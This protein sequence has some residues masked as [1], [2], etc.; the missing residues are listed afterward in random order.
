MST[1]LSIFP[2]L[3][4]LIAAVSCKEHKTTVSESAPVSEREKEKSRDIHLPSTDDHYRQV[5]SF[6]EE[7]PDADYKHAPEDAYESFNDMKFGIRIH[8]GI[9]SIWQMDHES[10]G[11]LKLTNEK[12]Q[13]YQNLYK[14]FNPTGFNAEEWMSFF[15]SAGLKVFAFT[16]KHHEGFS[17]FDTKAHVKQRANYTAPGGPKIEDCDLAYSI[18]ETPFKRDIVKELCDAAHKHK[19]KIDLYFSHPDWYDADFRPYNFHPLQTEDS[20][21]NPLRN[22]CD[23]NN[24]KESFSNIITP[25]PT[26]EATERMMARHRQQLTELLTN[27]GKIDMLC[28][29]QWFG[30][31]VWPQTKATIK[32][33]RKIQPDVM[34]RC[35]GIGNYGDYY[36]PEGFTPG[37]KEN[38]HMPWMVI[39]TLG[40]TF[41][42]DK[43][44]AHYKGSPWIIRNLVDAVAKGGNFMVGIGPDGTG[45]FHP[46]A[47]KQ[48]LEAGKW[49][50]INGQGIYATR[51]R[52]AAWKEGENIRYTTTK[53]KKYTYAFT[54]SWPGKQMTLQTV[55]PKKDSEIYML[56][57]EKPLQWSYTKNSLVINIP[58]QFQNAALRPCQTA[59]GFKI[60]E[61][62]N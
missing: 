26:A 30:P 45:K 62:N 57:Y 23:S 40:N 29:D 5:K 22:Y 19:I 55:K 48:L 10:W 31:M 54:L 6:V 34:L 9:Y 25:Q 41:S 51:P 12:K 53:D 18:M 47:V 33:L 16:T 37:D 32:E 60:E 50:K 38:T 56:G 24:F 8:W 1:K 42:Y 39:N 17:M 46:T 28:L 58:E 4:F 61:G 15:D 59:W 49:L 35:R 44:S 20:R 27:Y 2:V 7:I 36:T 14:S 11:F 43:V 3:F 21:L 52:A 13:E